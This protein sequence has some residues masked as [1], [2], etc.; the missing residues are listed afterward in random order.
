MLNEPLGLGV[1]AR[2]RMCK[3]GGM[4]GYV[5]VYKDGILTGPAMWI[6]LHTIDE[7]LKHLRKIAYDREIPPFY[8]QRIQTQIPQVMARFAKRRARRI[9]KEEEAVQRKLLSVEIT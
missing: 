6:P 4:H 5:K 8:V 9:R 3:C 2:F 7:A 1:R